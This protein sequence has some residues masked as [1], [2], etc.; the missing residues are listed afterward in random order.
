MPDVQFY[1]RGNEP[2]PEDENGLLEGR[3]DL[4]VE[5]LSSSSRKYD[6]VVKL[7]YYTSIGVP[8][9]RVVDPDGCTIE[10]LV[11]EGD[12]WCVATMVTGEEVFEPPTFEGLRIDARALFEGDG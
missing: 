9:Y 7:R 6:R 8:E 12:R 2:R 4:V 1:R 3:L 10:R 11:L 5:V